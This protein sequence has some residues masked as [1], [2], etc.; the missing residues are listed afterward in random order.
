[1]MCGNRRCIGSAPP[2]TNKPFRHE[3]WLDV[4]IAQPRSH[5]GWRSE[6]SLSGQSQG[7]AQSIEMLFGCNNGPPTFILSNI[8]NSASSCF[9]FGKQKPKCK[10]S[11]SVMVVE[12]C[13]LMPI[14]IVDKSFKLWC[15]LCELSIFHSMH[16]FHEMLEK[17]HFRSH[18]TFQLAFALQW[19]TNSMILCICYEIAF[20]LTASSTKLARVVLWSMSLHSDMACAGTWC[21]NLLVPLLPSKLAAQQ[22]SKCCKIHLHFGMPCNLVNCS[23]I[24]SFATW[25]LLTKLF[26]WNSKI[27]QKQFCMSH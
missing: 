18:Q 22:F 16:I 10:S 6:K 7:S 2:H 26:I 8:K 20:C 4:L 9:S 25:K 3:T 15:L 19:K 1:M 27:F 24:P 12:F 5:K 23:F 13:I 17:K 14:C 21:F 11:F